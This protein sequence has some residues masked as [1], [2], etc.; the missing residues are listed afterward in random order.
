MSQLTISHALSDRLRTVLRRDLKLPADLTIDDDA[1]LFGGDFDLDSL[2]AL[3][4]VA[5]VEK[6]FGIK[7]PNELVGREILQSVRTLS[8][9][10]AERLANGAEPSGAVSAAG[11]PG[12]RPPG[13]LQAMLDALPHGESFRFLTRLLT[14]QTGVCGEAMWEPRGT[15]PFFAGHFP[16]RPVVPGVLITEAMAQLSG[17]VGASGRSGGAAMGAISHVDVRFRR[18]IEPP[19]TIRL[20]SRLLE[21]VG[22]LSRFEVAALIA[23]DLAA[24]GLLTLRLT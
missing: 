11:V 17:I 20:T 14:L 16:G 2:D 12:V 19:T 21:A 22:E 18:M 23:D 7:V 5:S 3:M 1:M 6:E 8:E 4:L 15:E 9:Y 13:E 24:E 10:L